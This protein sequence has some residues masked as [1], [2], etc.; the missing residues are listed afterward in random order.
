MRIA[1]EG[2]GRELANVKQ[3]FDGH[4]DKQL[5]CAHFL[6]DIHLLSSQDMQWHKIFHKLFTVILQSVGIF[7]WSK[8]LRKF[9]LIILRQGEV[10]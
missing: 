7:G 9:R 5:R 3:P 2:L 10:E 6:N 8:L 1:T 4:R